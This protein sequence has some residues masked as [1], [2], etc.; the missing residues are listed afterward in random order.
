MRVDTC[1]DQTHLGHSCYPGIQGPV[2]SSFSIENSFQLIH[3]VTQNYVW[4]E[5]NSLLKMM[6]Q[7][8]P[9]SLGNRHRKMTSPV[10]QQKCRM[11]SFL[12]WEL[13]IAAHLQH[14]AS[15]YMQ[16]N[17]NHNRNIKSNIVSF[18]SEV[19]FD[20]SSGVSLDS[21]AQRQV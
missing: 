19:K 12:G 18:S 2:E 6:I 4:V 7:L 10:K 21:S 11:L 14:Q 9:V 15:D 8:V 13:C 1:V 16:C 3:I 5:M 17:S 20:N